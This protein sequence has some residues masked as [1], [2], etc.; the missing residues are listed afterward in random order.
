MVKVVERRDGFP[1][2]RLSYCGSP[3]F[4][5]ARRDRRSRVRRTES[6]DR[7]GSFTGSQDAGWPDTAG[8]MAKRDIYPAGVSGFYPAG[9]SFVW[10]TL[11]RFS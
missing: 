11:A 2:W 3:T 9:D 8:T 7:A 4:P 1:H 6:R 10:C 5:R